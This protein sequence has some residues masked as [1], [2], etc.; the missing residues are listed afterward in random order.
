MPKVVG[1]HLMCPHSNPGL[2]RSLGPVSIRGWCGKSLLLFCWLAFHFIRSIEYSIYL[3]LQSWLILHFQMLM[4]PMNS[5]PY[6]PNQKARKRQR[7][8]ARCKTLIYTHLVRKPPSWFANV[9]TPFFLFFILKIR[10]R[11]QDLCFCHIPNPYSIFKTNQLFHTSLLS[12]P[13]YLYSI[14]RHL[15][16]IRIPSSMVQL[17][18]HFL[19]NC[20]QHISIWFCGP[21]FSC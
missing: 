12:S 6:Y 14:Q 13:L 16:I 17:S 20:H 19:K 10:G 11:G 18:F 15:Q 3:Q 9:S 5:R 7:L 21:P 2:S 4:E 1:F 8:R